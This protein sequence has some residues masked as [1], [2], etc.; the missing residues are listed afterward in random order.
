MAA[1]LLTLAA[2]AVAVSILAQLL[3]LAL[4]ALL[5]AVR[6]P[7]DPPPFAEGFVSDAAGL[8][9]RGM[10]LAVL[11]V[12][13][14]FALANLTRNTGAALGIGFVYFAI[15]ES[16]VG[17]FRPGLLRWL[18]GPNVAAFL[19]PGG[20]ELPSGEVLPENSGLTSP[21]LQLTNLRAGLT[22]T[23]VVVVAIAI[24]TVLFK[25]RDIA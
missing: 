4:S 19:T 3:W 9:G 24:A 11:V 17:G 21:V 23:L 15:I 6:G 16:V 5:V 10:L 20:L 12:W 8:A 25:R 22:L 7:S 13:G 2:L 18:M 14:A 1:K